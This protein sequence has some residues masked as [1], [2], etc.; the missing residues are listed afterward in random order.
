MIIPE[1]EEVIKERMLR[2]PWTFLPSRAWIKHKIHE[3]SKD[4]A[5]VYMYFIIGC[6]VY[7]ICKDT[8][9]R[10]NRS[11]HIET[12]GVQNYK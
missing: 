11:K 3:V 10:F 4:P 2:C 8:L 1:S 5:K 7:G 12:L 9:R 6:A